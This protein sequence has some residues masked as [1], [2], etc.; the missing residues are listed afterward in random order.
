VAIL[1][2]V[3]GT[4]EERHPAG[5]AWTLKELQ[6]AVGGYI[7][8]VPH[9]GELQMLVNEEGKLQDLPVNQ[10]AT[11]LVTMIYARKGIPM[12]DFIVG[13]VLL[14]DGEERMR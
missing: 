10:T 8:L 3:D 7:E 1:L 6:T 13:D 11:F 4:E 14:L 9:L 12:L 2:R 5:T